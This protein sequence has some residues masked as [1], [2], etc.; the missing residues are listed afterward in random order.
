MLPVLARAGTG[1]ASPEIP[2]IGIPL[3]ISHFLE[4]TAKKYSPCEKLKEFSDFPGLKLWGSLP[5]LLSPPPPNGTRENSTWIQGILC[6]CCGTHTGLRGQ[7]CHLGFSA[8][9]KKIQTNPASPL[10]CLPRDTTQP[11]KNHYVHFASATEA[12]KDKMFKEGRN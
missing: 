4:Q 1:F 2:H 3:P 6:R 12:Q 8:Q 10:H 11:L 7:L 9:P 5:V